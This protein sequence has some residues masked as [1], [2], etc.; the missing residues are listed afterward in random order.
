M[1]SVTSMLLTGLITSGAPLFGLALFFGAAG[2]PL[3]T[4]LLVVAAGAFGR[5]GTLNS[6]SA[7]LFGLAGSV[8]GDCLCYAIG[9]FART[10]VQNRFASSNLWLKA[11]NTFNQRGGLAIFF[12]RFILTS[13]AF[14]INLIAGS[15][16]YSFRQYFSLVLTG[17]AIWI[18]VYGGL[19]YLFGNQWELI[20]D[21][22]VNFGGY[23][24]G[25]AAF[26]AGIYFFL[27]KQ[28]K[29]AAVLHGLGLVE[30]DAIF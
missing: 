28:R 23:A 26:S 1:N 2:L 20:S 15:S 24:I 30:V 16:G 12:T 3:P 18:S 9:Y 7:S 27:A 29:P 19:G 14:P 4:S 5:Q 8:A 13:T 22:L 25:L 11:Q 17:E 21:F 10:W 6:L